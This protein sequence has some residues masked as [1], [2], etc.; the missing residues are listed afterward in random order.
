MHSDTGFYAILTIIYIS[1]PM[2]LCVP[3]PSK[4]QPPICKLVQIMNFIGLRLPNITENYRLANNFDEDAANSCSS[5]NIHEPSAIPDNISESSY[6]TFLVKLWKVHTSSREQMLL[7]N[8]STLIQEMK[9]FISAVKNLMRNRRIP[10]PAHKPTTNPANKNMSGFETKL[11]T[12]MV[13]KRY[14]MWV[15]WTNRQL[16]SYASLQ[17]VI[18]CQT[19]KNGKCNSMDGHTKRPAR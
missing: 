3:L 5:G 11:C 1:L 9:G 17:R 10:I 13:L 6:N 12:Y 15:V 8:Q 2:G 16:L 19:K 18:C 4:P 7:F 14:S